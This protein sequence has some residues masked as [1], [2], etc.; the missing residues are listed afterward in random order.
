MNSSFRFDTPRHTRPANHYD[1]LDQNLETFLDTVFAKY[2]VTAERQGKEYL[3]M[4]SA[5]GDKCY[6]YRDMWNAA[7]IPF[8][9]GVA[10]YLL[11][12]L[13]PWSEGVRK[14]RTGWVPVDT[15]VISQYP[16]FKDDLPAA[17]PPDKTQTLK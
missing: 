5:H 8:E 14:T 4:I 2:P 13:T 15:W 12:Y 16:T 1:W 6:T 9:H 11:S 7:G 17:N 3:G 10:I